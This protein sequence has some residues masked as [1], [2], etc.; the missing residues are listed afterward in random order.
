MKR[1]ECVY[2]LVNHTI[3]SS[4]PYTF[5]VGWNLE[6]KKLSLL[7]IHRAL[8]YIQRKEKKKQKQRGKQPF[9]EN[10]ITC[11]SKDTSESI[12]FSLIQWFKWDTSKS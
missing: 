3:Q 12:R 6:R 8:V 4:I 9:A 5:T 11:H 7:T 1:S 2:I 10:N